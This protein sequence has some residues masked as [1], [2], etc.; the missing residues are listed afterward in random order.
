MTPEPHLSTLL[1]HRLRYGELSSA[2]QASAEAHLGSCEACRARHQAQTA[3]RRAFEAA[4]PRMVFPE[5]AAPSLWQRLRRLALPI[6][7]PTLAVALALVAVRVWPSPPGLVPNDDTR[8][9]GG[10]ILEQPGLAILVEGHGLLGEDEPLRPGDRIQLR[11]PA[12]LGVEAW[13]GDRDGPVGRFDLDPT[14]PTLS[15]FALTLDGEEGDEELI[16]VLSDEPLDR[17]AAS[18][19]MNGEALPGVLVERI[20]LRKV[21]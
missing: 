6:L 9:K 2:E 7:I 3:F 19:A 17:A 21:R 12:G 14:A 10:L 16:L 11:L 1:L 5:P 20:L 15:P 4:P 8:L 13:V 18:R